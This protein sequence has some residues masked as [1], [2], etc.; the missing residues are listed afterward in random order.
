V[1]LGEKTDPHS[2]QI[3]VVNNAPR[4]A[5]SEQASE[6]TPWKDAT[7]HRVKI[8][9][10]VA[11]GLIE[12]Y[13]DD[14]EKPTHVAHDKTF[15]WGRIGI[16]T[17]D[18]KGLWDDIEV[19]GVVVEPPLAVL[20]GG[21]PDPKGLT[22]TKWT[23]GFE[24]P[25]PVAIS[26]DPQGRAYVTQT[27]RRKANDLDIRTTPT[28]SQMISASPPPRRRR[29]FTASSS[30]RRTAPSTRSGSRISPATG[31]TTCATSPP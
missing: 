10:T 16:G 20:S 9:R 25:D 5:I 2:N 21:H 13:F 30:R 26:F 15:A 31:S 22:Y 8:V 24:V 19:R 18:D 27:Q 4:V 17:F 1:H 23:P 11:T 14:M 28:G 7:W 3:F 29:L 12:I 6:G